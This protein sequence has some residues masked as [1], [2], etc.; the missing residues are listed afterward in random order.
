MGA[1]AERFA[2]RVILTNDNPRTEDPEAILAEIRAGFADPGAAT[3]IPDRAEAIHRAV[4]EA[5]PGDVIVVAGKGHETYQILGT[6]RR[7][8]DDR[9]EVRRQFA[10][11]TSAAPF[12]PPAPRPTS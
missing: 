8:F 4:E 11:R 7:A 3:V 9:A 1:V 6:Q 2:D 12:R 10:A 5:A